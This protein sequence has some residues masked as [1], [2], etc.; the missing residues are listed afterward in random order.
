MSHKDD[1]L[2]AADF[3]RAYSDSADFQAL[4]SRLREAAESHERELAEA[5]DGAAVSP[6]LRAVLSGMSLRPEVVVFAEAM[7]C[8]LRLNDHKE[9]WRSMPVGYLIE[10]LH[11][12]TREMLDC[13]PRRQRDIL[14]EAADVANFCM[15]LSTLMIDERI[16]QI[17]ALK[18]P[19]QGATSTAP[20]VR[21]SEVALEQ[22][23]SAKDGATPSPA[24]AVPDDLV[25]LF[26]NL[27]GQ[28]GGLEAT[29]KAFARHYEARGMRKLLGIAEQYL[30]TN[31]AIRFLRNDMKDA[32][33]D[34]ERKP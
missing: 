27:A 13:F 32:I 5:R 11:E 18:S 7:E 19:A 26:F 33:A 34:L 30:G 24:A 20:Q 2:R 22:Q 6:E 25:K 1:L 3:F 28:D 17:R 14:D 10:R 12:E 15:M 21:A 29:C 9:N 16:A 4:A 31:D 8:K 23:T